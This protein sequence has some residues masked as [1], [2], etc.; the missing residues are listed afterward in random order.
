MFERDEI[1]KMLDKAGTQLRAMIL[2]GVNCGLGNTDC[3]SLRVTHLDL[4]GGWLNFPRPKTGID[5]RCK[6]WPETVDAIK[7][8]LAERR[9][10]KDLANEHLVFITKHGA[11]W[12]KVRTIQQKDGTLK[13]MSDDA[14]SKETKKVLKALHI[15]GKRNFYALR[16]TFETI[17]GDSRDQVAVNAIMGHVDN[18]MAGVYRER[19]HDDRLAAVAAHVRQWLFGKTTTKSSGKRKAARRPQLAIV[20]AEAAG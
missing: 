3:G 2:L 11:P 5:R 7:M 19:I 6:L 17:A 16:H 8:V 4:D 18:S 10:P 13:V 15:N 14:V 9:V 20:R 12:T 1:R